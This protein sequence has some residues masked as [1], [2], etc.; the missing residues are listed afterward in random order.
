MRE[1]P[2]FSHDATFGNGSVFSVPRT[3]TLTRETGTENWLGDVPERTKCML[4]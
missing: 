4:P 3:G 1:G 2:P